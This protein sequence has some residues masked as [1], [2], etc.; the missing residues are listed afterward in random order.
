MSCLS[1]N[2]NTLVFPT[3]LGVGVKKMVPAVSSF[4]FWNWTWLKRTGSN[5][6]SASVMRVASMAGW[7]P[8]TFTSWL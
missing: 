5:R 3:R 6:A 1:K 8:A 7:Y 4:F 2:E